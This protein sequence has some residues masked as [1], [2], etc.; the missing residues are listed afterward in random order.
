MSTLQDLVAACQ[1]DEVHLRQQAQSRAESWHPWLVPISNASPTGEDPGYDDD[2]QRIREEVNKLSCID[3]GLICTLAEKLLTTTAKDIRIA[4][5]YCWARLHQDGEAGF[6]EGLELLA[7]L[8]QRYGLQLHPQRERSRKPALEWLAGSRVLDSLSLWPEVVREHAQRTIGSLLLISDSLKAEAEVSQPE[9]NALY[10]AL[11]ARLMKAGGVDAVIPQNASNKGQ[12]QNSSYPTEPDAPVLSRITSGQDL[13][14]Q[15]RTLTEYLREQPNGWLA[16]H[17]LM[18]SLRHDTL[19]AIPAPDAEGKT[20]IEPPRAD[21]RAM[22]KRLYLQQSWLEILEQADS[23]FS[24]GANHLWLDL[25]WYIHQALM[26]SGQDVLADIITADLKGLLHRLTGLETLAFNDG[27]P[28]ADE[29]TLSWIKQS[30]L[31]DISGW[32]DEPVS[33][34]CEMDNDI[35]ALEPEALEKADTDGLDAALHWLQTRPGTDSIKDK[36][37]LRLLMARIAEQKGK[38]E[39]ALHLL[40]ELDSTARSI[41]LTQWTP[42]LL[43]EVKSRRL[44]LLRMKATRSETDK[45]RLQPEMDLLLSGLIALDPASSAVLCG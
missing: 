12:S 6:A 34:A 44:R 45:S 26:K 10:S 4:T 30:V 40:G 9:L 35:L 32:R 42:A 37:L 18:K 24:R 22:L 14:A 20:R 43:F 16:A 17:R 7:G 19:S 1:A 15:A 8:L 28:F 21:Q 25:Q 39:L 38:N 2:F 5:C 29:V 23:A 11:E 33:A 31:D 27:T 36:W 13:L 3:T 41:T